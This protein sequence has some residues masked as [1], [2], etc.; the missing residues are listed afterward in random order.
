MSQSKRILIKLGGAALDTDSTVE[1][2]GQALHQYRSSGHQV[3]VVH[4]GGPAIN[5]ELRKRGITWTFV[6]GQRVTTPE[7]IDTIESVLCGSVNRK[8]VRS[9]AS[10]GLPV[11]GLA[12]TDQQTLLCSQAAPE[13]G[14][15]GAIEKVQAQWIEELLNLANSPIPVF[16]PVGAGAS[17]E[18][19]N[20]NA[21][22]AASHL[23]VALKVD[24]MLFLTDQPGV[25]DEEGECISEV[26]QTGIQ[27]MIACKVVSGGMLAK[28][29]AVLHALAQGVA[30]VRILKAT[31][32]VQALKNPQVGTHCVLAFQNNAIDFSSMAA[33]EDAI[34][35]EDVYATV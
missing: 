20:I 22:W 2:L 27:N 12:G 4:G 33:R 28:S 16:A 31:D 19:Y 21:D 7:M 23:G 26:D 24:E 5:N 17:G 18:C 6:N 32:I 10:A 35:A 8:L 34:A 30:S 3:I 14:L 9:L 29:Q 11:M 1:I 13:L 25:L 15:V